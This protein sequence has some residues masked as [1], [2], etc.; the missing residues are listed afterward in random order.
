MICSFRFGAD[1]RNIGRKNG[2]T[3]NQNRAVSAH[4]SFALTNKMQSQI[5]SGKASMRFFATLSRRNRM[6]LP[7]APS[8]VSIQL[9]ETSNV[10]NKT[11]SPTDSG[12]EV[13]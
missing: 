4:R 11:R 12:S 5:S 6:H 10:C 3:Y 7:I 8:I 1:N 13:N 2:D 9:K